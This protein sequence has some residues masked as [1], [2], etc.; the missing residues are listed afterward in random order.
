MRTWLRIS[1]V[2][3]ATVAILCAAETGPSLFQKALTKE[4][5][6]ADPAGA[7]LLYERVVKEF[8]GDRKLAA[9]ALFRVGECHLALGHAEARKAFERLVREFADQAELASSARAKLATLTVPENKPRFTKIRIPTKLPESSAYALSPD[10]TQLAYVSEGS[11][12][13]VPV[14]GASDPTLAGAPRRVTE[15]V[16]GWTW[17]GDIA[18]S[19]DGNWLA[20][21]V[22]EQSKEGQDVESCYL[23]QL[24]TGVIRRIP[25]GPMLQGLLWLDFYLSLSPD[26]KWLAYPTWQEGETWA[27]KSVYIAPTSGGIPRRLTQRATV[28]PSFS[29]DGKRIAYVGTVDDKAWSHTYPRGREIW[30]VPVSGGTPVLLYAHP[31]PGSLLSPTWSPM[32]K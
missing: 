28:N 1:M 31:G 15:Q 16:Q 3:L 25:L 17:C 2:V 23:V 4:R 26:A 22:G 21:N 12:W 27:Q 13:S 29:P 8:P 32:E 14:H 7:I 9:E 10:G 24:T 5:A 11:V 30:I 20:L 18:W 19:Y 6:D